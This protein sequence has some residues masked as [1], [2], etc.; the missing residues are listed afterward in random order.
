M[1]NDQQ[2][3]LKALIAERDELASLLPYADG[4]AYYRDKARI[5]ALND[6]I[7]SLESKDS[8]AEN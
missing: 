4:S 5:A 3:H 8:K 6:K 2:A 7:S 1:A